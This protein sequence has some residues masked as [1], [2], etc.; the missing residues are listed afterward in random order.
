[1]PKKRFLMHLGEIVDKAKIRQMCA[2]MEL[3]KEETELMLFR[4]CDGLNV[5]Q[6]TG[7][8]FYLTADRQKKLA[9][10]LETKVIGWIIDHFGFFNDKQVKYLQ[11]WC[12]A[13]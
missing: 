1:M 6:M 10:V 8:P 9:N 13:D 2:L 11:K 7:D 3:T 5:D 12:N 4:F